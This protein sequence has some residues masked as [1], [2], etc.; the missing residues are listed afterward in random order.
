[1]NEP[2]KNSAPTESKR[3]KTQDEMAAEKAAE[4]NSFE[5]IDIEL[6]RIEPQRSTSAYVQ[7]CHDALLE[8]RFV[9]KQKQELQQFTVEIV[10][11]PAVQ[12]MIERMA[13]REQQ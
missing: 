13:T 2:H 5:A 7:K 4:Y 6:I 1:M 11:S 8:R 10:A 3:S 12:G 9:L